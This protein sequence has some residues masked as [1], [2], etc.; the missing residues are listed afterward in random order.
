MANYAAIFGSY[1]RVITRE[2]RGTGWS[3]RRRITHRVDDAN[4]L[5]YHIETNRM[6]LGGRTKA[7]RETHVLRM[8]MFPELREHLLASGFV[9]MRLFTRMKAGAAEASTH[10]PRLVVVCIRP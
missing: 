4:M 7:W 8:W 2:Q 1:K 10:V 3:I 6:I 9:D 5:W